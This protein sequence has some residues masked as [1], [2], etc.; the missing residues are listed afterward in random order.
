MVVLGF[1]PG[2]G[3]INSPKEYSFIDY[4]PK[5]GTSY[6]RL[7]Q[8][9]SDGSF[10]FSEILEI[11]FMKSI[12]Q[13]FE[14]SQNYPN[15]FNPSTKINIG[16]PDASL[17]G[18]AIENSN[19]KLSIFDILGREIIVLVNENLEPSYYEVEWNAFGFSSGMYFY[20]IVWNGK[21]EVKKL[22]LTK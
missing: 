17:N 16:I 9:N 3:N 4:N 6:Y 1:V 7:K 20:Q 18:E 11:S 19:V 21:S 12:P 8:I 10:E 22:M 14:L 15:P 13:K 5:S 2:H